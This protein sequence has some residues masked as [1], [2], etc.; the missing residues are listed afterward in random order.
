MTLTSEELAL[1]D[2]SV[3]NIGSYRDS[4][5]GSYRDSDGD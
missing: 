2:V 4:D 1:A 5:V 3:S